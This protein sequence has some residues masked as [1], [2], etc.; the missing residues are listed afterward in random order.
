MTGLLTACYNPRAVQPARRT[1]VLVPEPSSATRFPGE[2]AMVN[3]WIPDPDLLPLSPWP[4]ASSRCC[5][6]G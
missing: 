1:R 4:S 6:R 5:S 3:A 2:P